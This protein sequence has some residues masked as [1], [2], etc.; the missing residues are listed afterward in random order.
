MRLT[1]R[2]RG[3]ANADTAWRRYLH[4]A[5][6]PTWAPQIRSVETGETLRAGMRGRLRPAVGPA[7][8]FVITSVDPAARSW[9]WRVQAGPVRMR[10]WH[11]VRPYGAS[12]AATRLRVEGA[13][14]VVLAYAPLAL[15]ALRRLVRP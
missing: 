13:L 2:A 3:A 11:E 15:I 1:L 8:A 7:V 5:L 12:G 10:L 4:P 9:S 6:W 14:P